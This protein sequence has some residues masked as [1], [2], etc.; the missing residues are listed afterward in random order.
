MLHGIQGT[1]MTRSNDVPQR[2]F[3]LFT[4]YVIIKQ[5]VFIGFTIIIVSP[6]KERHDYSL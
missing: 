2:Q 1:S 4:S 6:Y 3:H 5:I